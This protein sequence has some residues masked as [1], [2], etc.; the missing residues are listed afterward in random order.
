MKEKEEEMLDTYLEEIIDDTE[1]KIKRRYKA[2]KTI[3][4]N[5]FWQY[6][7]EKLTKHVGKG[8]KNSL[9][10]IKLVNENNEVI[11]ESHDRASIE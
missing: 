1:E 7:F 3:K 6:T 11:K 5:R 4:K 9:K 10:K 8:E 2:I